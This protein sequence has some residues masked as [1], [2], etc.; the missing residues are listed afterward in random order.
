MVIL[1]LSICFASCKKQSNT[2]APTNNTPPSSTS[3]LTITVN[4][5]TI[6]A[7]QSVV[8]TASG[9]TTYSWSTGATTSSITVSPTST[10]SY[11]VT[12]TTGSNT[13]TAT[14]VVTVS[15][16][17][18]TARD[19]IYFL[20]YLWIP[21]P[22]APFAYH[23]DTTNIRILI[24]GV[25]V[26]SNKLNFTYTGNNGIGNIDNNNHT[27]GVLTMKK[28]DTLTLVV[29]SF[30]YFKPYMTGQMGSIYINKNQIANTGTGYVNSPNINPTNFVNPT[31]YNAGTDRAFG[32]A[33]YNGSNANV[34]WYL[35]TKLTYTWINP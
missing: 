24:N 25:K 35:G 31:S 1:V 26:P 15:T 33:P 13:G 34:Y 19:T 8:L 9:A 32:L 5:A 23:Y 12:G 2:P 28:N 20:A 21:T 29:D 11:T 22:T 10:T 4:S 7:G 30:F 14:A 3:T 17:T 18:T 6:T 27:L 16:G